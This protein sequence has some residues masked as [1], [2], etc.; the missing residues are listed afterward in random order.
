MYGKVNPEIEVVGS[1]SHG[2][3]AAKYGAVDFSA[4]INPLGP[5]KEILDFMK[6]IRPEHLRLY[7]DTECTALREEI[8]SSLSIPADSII[9]GNGSVEI[10][11]LVCQVFLEKGDEVLIPV[12]TFSEYERM[13]KIYGGVCTFVTIENLRI[14][15][16]K[17]I[18]KMGEK[19][20]I[21]F[22]CNPNNP[23]GFYSDDVSEIIEEASRKKILVFLDEAFIDFTR[24]KSFARE[25]NP[26]LIVSKSATKIYSIPALRCGFAF[27]DRSLIEYLRKASTPWNV[28]YVAQEAV[29]TALKNKKFI[30]ETVTFIEKEKGYILSE[31][32][33]IP[34]FTI[35]PSD[36]N[37][38]LVKTK[39]VTSPNL[40]KNLLERGILLRDCSNFRGLDETYVRFC[41]RTREDNKRLIRELRIYG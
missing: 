1:F 33:K 7:P 41:V 38:F 27:S 20:K 37:F 36:A 26:Y 2:D 3:D 13:V 35:H 5:P 24:K 23:T 9:V 19:T 34:S 12:P 15:P 29:R 22:L 6:G 31:A 16:S 11:R 18:E 4:S 25:I 32:R 10:L 40:R 17:I 14:D 28:N 30:E 8:S 39:N 21:I